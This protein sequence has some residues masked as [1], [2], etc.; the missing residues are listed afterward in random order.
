MAIHTNIEDGQG[1]DSLVHVTPNGELIIREIEYSQ[2]V[3]QTLDVDNTAYNF[4]TPIVGQNFIITGIIA[5]AAASVGSG[6]T[7]TI[8]E[9]DSPTSTG[10][11]K[12]LF[13]FFLAASTP[14]TVVPIM[15]K[16]SEGVFLNAK[17]NDDDVFMTILGYYV[18]VND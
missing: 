13:T 2:S 18:N 7:V 5:D 1:T 10:V 17:T 3:F 15:V 9:A 4:Y 12:N 8:Y 14:K 6:A 16:T 11:D